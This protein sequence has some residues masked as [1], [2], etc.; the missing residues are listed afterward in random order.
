MSEQGFFRRHFVP[1]QGSSNNIPAEYIQEHMKDAGL[2]SAMRTPPLT[3]IARINSFAT[4][5]TNELLER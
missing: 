2:N 4:P 5:E 3:Y 1:R